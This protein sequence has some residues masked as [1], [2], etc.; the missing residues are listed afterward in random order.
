LTLF[1]LSGSLKR[2]R[3]SA[4]IL[5]VKRDHRKALAFVW[6]FTIMSAYD[7]TQNTTA[8]RSAEAETVRK[9]FSAL[10]IDERITTLFKVEVDLVADV[11]ENV[12]ANISKAVEDFTKA[13]TNSVTP[14]ETAPGSGETTL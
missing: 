4:R 10:S 1:C 3:Q 12:A 2:V 7:E 6:R 5:V 9:L 8:G 11:V 13:C 14:P